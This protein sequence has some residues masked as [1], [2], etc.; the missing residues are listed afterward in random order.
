MSNLKYYG[1]YYRAGMTMKQKIAQDR[2]MATDKKQAE[3][4]RAN[5]NKPGMGKNGGS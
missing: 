3:K 1:Q 4:D 2:N 5:A